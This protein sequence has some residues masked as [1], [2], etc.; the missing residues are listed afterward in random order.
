M[1]GFILCKEKDGGHTLVPDFFVDNYMPEADGE[2]VKIYLYLLR[3]LKSGTQELSVSLIADRFDHTENY[4]CR[5]LRYW[6]KM[7]LLQLEYDSAAFHDTAKRAAGH[8]AVRANILTSLGY[9]VFRVTPRVVRS[10]VG[11]ELLARQ[12]AS[13]LGV[14]LAEPDEIQALRRRRLYVQLMPQYGDA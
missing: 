13:A 1:S 14:T 4:I 3:C 10:L 6:E 12:L 7:K 9:R 11:V 5:A 8:D 2:Y